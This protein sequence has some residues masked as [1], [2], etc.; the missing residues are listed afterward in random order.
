MRQELFNLDAYFERIGY[1]GKT[2]T[3]PETLH[4]L[5][6]AH[7]LQIPFE[8]LDIYYGKPVC[9]DRESLFKKI[10][11]GKRGGY[12]FEMN[13]LF[14]FVL[15]ALGFKVA[16]LLARGTLDGKTY[17]A[18]THQVLLVE[19]G[20]KQWMADVGF[21]MGGIMVP[22]LLAE[23]LEQQQYGHTYRLRR[24]PKYGYIFQQKTAAGYQAMFAFTLE[25]CCE[26][27]FVMAHHYTATFPGS[28]FQQARFCTIPTP[29]G[30]MTLFEMHFKKPAGG[31]M[32]ERTLSGE[33]EFRHI[34]KQYFGLDL[35]LIAPGRAGKDRE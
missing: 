11:L 32:T 9:L 22:L 21:G 34:L 23:E 6:L 29:E 26:E 14:S 31:R 20:G 24:D 27:D 19:A 30:R 33:S 15:K 28:F 12:C 1:R 5:H 17:M 8:N 4:E 35:E 16:D 10:V 25:E 13:G 2:D 7:T 18:K 3:S